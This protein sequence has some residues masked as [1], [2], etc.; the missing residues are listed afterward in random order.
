[1]RHAVHGPYRSRKEREA[2]VADQGGRPS[3]HLDALKRNRL[4][5]GIDHA[6]LEARLSN[7]LASMMPTFN[8]DSF[9]NRKRLK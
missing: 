9:R 5:S 8:T 3:N 1:M 2:P 4:R 7:A 6:P